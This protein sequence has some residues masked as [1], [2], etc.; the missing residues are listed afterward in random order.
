MF[1]AW[2][3]READVKARE[4]AL[5]IRLRQLEDP[6]RAAFY[7]AYTP[8]LKDPDTYAVLNWLCLAGLHHF[9]LGRLA[10]GAFNLALMLTGVV[11]LFMAPI[12]GGALIALVFVA[13]LPALFRSQLVVADYNAALGE[14]T[15]RA[16]HRKE[17]HSP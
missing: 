6:D 11:L 16:L 15:L 8:R 17:R 2:R 1:E 7:R 14:A 10:A 3:V 5:R 13:E 12:I 4:D 9:Y